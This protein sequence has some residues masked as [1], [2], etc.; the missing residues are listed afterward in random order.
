M[1]IG[2]PHIPC[3][4]YP[5]WFVRDLIILLVLYPL[6][7]RIAP[8]L[9]LVC[10]IFLF[11]HNDQWPWDWLA[12]IPMPK[13]SNGLLFLGGLI[14]AH[15]PLD[16]WKVFFLRTAPPLVDSLS[17]DPVGNSS[18][19][20]L[21]LSHRRVLHFFRGSCR[22]RATAGSGK[23]HHQAGRPSLLPL[24][25]IPCPSH[26]GHRTAGRNMP[27]CPVHTGMGLLCAPRAHLRHEHR[28]V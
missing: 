1:G 24:L 9:A 7:R 22:R 14:A 19:A 10:A 11:S 13:P 4:D 5:L 20:S 17:S 12:S 15:L 3:A 18:R 6:Y 8:L 28:R 23:S 16:R 2:A 26:P 21:P 25:C 27:P